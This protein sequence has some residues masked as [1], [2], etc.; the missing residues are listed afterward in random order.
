MVRQALLPVLLGGGVGLASALVMGRALENLLFE[1]TGNDPV[2]LGLVSLLIGGVAVLASY[3]P[4]W[5]A[6]RLDPAR[7]LRAD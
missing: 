2:T 4:A 3:L 6:S 5:R 7:T 1:V